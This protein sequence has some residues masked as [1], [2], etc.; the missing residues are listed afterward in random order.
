MLL[1]PGLLP[2]VL[3]LLV[4]G[5]DET[6]LSPFEFPESAAGTLYLDKRIHNSSLLPKPTNYVM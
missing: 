3:S 4:L 1:P 5:E 2:N 6:V